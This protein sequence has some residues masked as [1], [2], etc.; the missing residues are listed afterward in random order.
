MLITERFEDGR[1]V[2]L[3]KLPL[4]ILHLQEEPTS[5]STGHM[6]GLKARLIATLYAC[7]HFLVAD[8]TVKLPAISRDFLHVHYWLHESMVTK[9]DFRNPHCAE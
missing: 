3:S 7:T 4:T 9:R 8:V 2:K 6:E 5:T 1:T